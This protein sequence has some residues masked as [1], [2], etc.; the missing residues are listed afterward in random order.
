MINL[1]F[2]TVF[3]RCTTVEQRETSTNNNDTKIYEH[4]K[5][6]GTEKTWL[7]PPKSSHSNVLT[8][9]LLDAWKQRTKNYVPRTKHLNIDSTPKYL[10]R[11]FLES[12]PYLRQHA[13]NPVDWRPWGPESLAEAKQKRKLIFLSV[14]YS[15]CH[16][17][18]VMEE[19]S[20]EDEEIAAILNEFYIPIKVDREERPDVDAIYMRAVRTLKG[21]GGWPMS[22]WLTDDTE[23]FYAET[24][25]PARNGDRGRKFGFLSLLDEFH[26]AYSADPNS[27]YDEAHRITEKI[28]ISL[29][30]PQKGN[31]P[32]SDILN[33]TLSVIEQEYDPIYG[34]RRGA[35]K[36]PSSI[37]LSL[38]LQFA[39][40]GD[41]KSKDMAIQSL[42]KMRNGGIYDH[43]AGGFHRY[44]VD[45]RWLVPHFEK[46]L[47][48]NAQ[49]AQDY[50]KADI[51]A[52]QENFQH[53]TRHILDYV[54][55]EMTAPE[56]GFYSATDADS[57]TPDGHR[58]EGYFFTWTIEELK[59]LLPASQLE[60]ILRRYKITQKGNFEGR[61]ILS[62]KRSIAEIANSLTISEEEVQVELKLAHQLLYDHRAT[63]PAPILDTKIITAWNGLM[64][65]SFAKA[66][67]WLESE[68]YIHAA[69]RAANFCLEQLFVNET[70]YRIYADKKNHHIGYIEDYAFLIAALLDLLETTGNP[71]WLNAALQLDDK[72]QKFYESSDGGWYRTHQDH[73]D[74]LVRELPSYDGAEPSG[75]SIMMQNLY[76]FH[77]LTAADI[78]RQ[79]AEKSFSIYGRKIQYNPLSLDNMLHALHWKNNPPQEVFLLGHNSEDLKPM[80]DMLKQSKSLNRIFVPVHEH[81]RLELSKILPPLQ[82]KTRKNNKATAYVCQK[83]SCKKPTNN[84]NEFLKQLN[85]INK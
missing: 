35:P 31:I 66:G 5:S 79:R 36:F 67:F 34:G 41:L 9:N 29:E 85:T 69:I 83:G 65:S 73:S 61:N 71:K 49:L 68:E 16:W 60:I 22:V 1:I 75:A 46:M 40:Y 81:Q 32:S 39:S 12:S 74:L 76:R 53:T 82:G 51:L 37:P 15:T 58:E 50:L 18:H 11:L 33:Y 2:I 28:K 63:R 47:Y 23:P 25:I 62:V 42:L 57:L 80:I 43:L 72:V 77:A 24:Y 27:I 44:T 8:Q 52:P 54:L 19:E 13:H 45:E 17:C 26:I 10:N 21:R 38:L 70:L 3:L 84:P 4:E 14:G 78:Y 20:F 59:N 6:W 55:R 56:G 30:K 64:I 7:T 48:D